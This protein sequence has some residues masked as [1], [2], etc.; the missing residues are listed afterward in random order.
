MQAKETFF[1]GDRESEKRKGAEIKGKKWKERGK[2]NKNTSQL[3]DFPQAHSTSL[4]QRCSSWKFLALKYLLCLFSC[5]L[6]L[7]P[8]QDC[9]EV[10]VIL[11]RGL[12]G[13]W[14]TNK[15]IMLFMCANPWHSF[16]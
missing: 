14:Y 8:R 5:L 13:S 15:H 16:F 12:F 3:T 10:A 1:S 9:D 7:D 6:G 2:E 11:E 4:L